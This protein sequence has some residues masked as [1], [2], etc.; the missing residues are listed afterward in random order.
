MH[1]PRLILSTALGLSLALQ[2]SAGTVSAA[3]EIELRPEE[4][5][6]TGVSSV[7]PVGWT[8]VGGGLYARGDFPQEPT[9]IAMQS[10]PLAADRVWPS[11][12][13]QLGLD[14]I[15][16]PTGS[17][18]TERFHWAL[19]RAPE[20][21]TIAGIAMDVELALVE[22][23]GATHIVVLQAPA[24]EFDDLREQVFVP[25]VEAFA[26]LAAE[27]TAGSSPA[28]YQSE[29]VTF[30]GGS[31][32]VD[33]AGT[34]TLPDGTGPHPAVVLMSG[35]GP[36]D[37]DE[38]LRPISAIR[39]FALIADA[40]TPAGVAVLR[41]DDRGVGQSSGVYDEATIEELA[42]DGAAALEYLR[43]RDD[44][45][46]AR[47]GLL[48]H[49][50]GGLYAAMLAA[51]DPGIAFVVGLAAP[52]V[53]GVELIVAQNEAITRSSGAG[54]EEAAR[55]AEFAAHAMPL[56]R[57]GDAEGVEAALRDY[58]GATWDRQPEPTRALLGEREEYVESQVQ[59][60][61]PAL[62]TDWFRSILAYDPASDWQRVTAPMLGIF[63]G[64]DV[65]V[66]ADQNESALRAELA[67]G[68]NEDVEILVLPDANHLFQSAETGAI[69]EYG[70]LAA[71]FTPDLLPAILDW[72]TERIGLAAD[73]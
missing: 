64:L 59:S 8:D 55:A 19:Y 52:A 35:S 5:P 16:E 14:E 27:P 21:V 22:A 46:P 6:A 45:D 41:Y 62:L 61:L 67:A 13:P 43:G 10:V 12:L 48:G 26:V 34:L 9:L 70:T 73:A 1:R 18:G 4:N 42:A 3:T 17:L 36:Q 40:L 39:P 72:V 53:D 50:E 47:I 15:P 57:D 49:S 56:A 28:A 63:G 54:E 38:S 69:Q 24:D 32:G 2:A 65:Q 31:E 37:R 60:Q 58:I 66:L 29:E 7:V 20:P 23:D 44:I 33:L 71:E 11:I 68:G 30:H 25:A 51:R